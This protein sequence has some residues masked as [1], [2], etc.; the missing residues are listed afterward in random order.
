MDSS[1]PPQEGEDRFITRHGYKRQQNYSTD[2]PIFRSTIKAYVVWTDPTTLLPLTDTSIDLFFYCIFNNGTRFVLF[3][4][5][6]GYYYYFNGIPEDK[7]PTV[8]P[9]H[10]CLHN[11]YMPHSQLH[12]PILFNNHRKTTNTRIMLSSFI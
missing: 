4:T 12:V 8:H 3:F 1:H 6:Y 10:L 2:W 7:C 9:P 5:S 11:H